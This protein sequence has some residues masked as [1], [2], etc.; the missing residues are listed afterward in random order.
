MNHKTSSYRIQVL[1]R[2]FEILNAVAGE[3]PE[4][5]VSELASRLRLRRSTAHRLVMVLESSSFLQRDAATGKCRLG[6]RIMQLGLVALSRLD[7]AQVSRPHLS[8]LVDEVQETAHIGLLSDS[9]IISIVNVQCRH[10]LRFPSTV[11]TTSPFYCT[12]Q[13]KVIL[14]FRAPEQ[15]NALLQDVILRPYTANTIT[16]KI[17]FFSELQAIRETGYA[18]DNEE[19]EVG[20]RCVAAP[21]RDSEGEVIAALSIAGPAFRMRDDRITALSLAVV[22][23]AARLSASLGYDAKKVCGSTS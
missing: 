12:S 22:Q 10:P 2:A 14:A 6:P 13:G 20:L 21:V 4:L 3:G 11:G 7:L 17:R 1:D 16:S 15:V 18:I 9:E 5:G 8:R 19:F 23:A